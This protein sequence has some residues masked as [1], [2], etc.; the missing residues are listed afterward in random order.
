MIF[1]REKRK[2]YDSFWNYIFCIFRKSILVTE[3]VS[4]SSVN[5]NNKQPPILAEL[6]IRIA[7][8]VK[9]LAP[10]GIQTLRADIYRGFC[11]GRY[12]KNA[13]R[14]N[15]FLSQSRN[16]ASFTRMSRIFPDDR[17]GIP[18]VVAYAL[19]IY[20]S[21][22]FARMCTHNFYV[23]RMYKI[24]RRFALLSL[25]PLLPSFFL[26]C[27]PRYV[28]HNEANRS[29]SVCT[30]GIDVSRRLREGR[31]KE[32]RRKCMKK[33][34]QR[35]RAQKGERHYGASMYWVVR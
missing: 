2:H 11:R 5:F 19:F 14:I 24:S 9:K 18:R 7:R 27:P 25:S 34:R 1:K 15:F 6:I 8:K 32:N 3:P 31:S 22:V 4:V 13:M 33:E 23:T 30:I 21:S 17:R 28:T 29:C 20:L 12:V 26:L 35:K 10:S 16:A